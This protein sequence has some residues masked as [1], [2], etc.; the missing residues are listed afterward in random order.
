MM[1]R[2]WL[3]WFL[4]I[5]TSL[6]GLLLL[7]L[8]LLPFVSLKMLLDHLSRDGTL[9]MLNP[10]NAI[11][12]RFLIGAIIL[13]LWG[14]AYV[15]FARKWGNVGNFFVQLWKDTRS[16][17][18]PERISSPLSTR[19]FL[20][21]LSAVTIF[22]VVSRLAHIESPMIHDESF[23]VVNFSDSFF[24]A[25]SDYS[26]VNNHV[27]HTILVFLSI[28]IFGVAPWVARLPA[29]LAGILIIPGIYLLAK[30][31]YDPWTG[32]LASLLA[33]F[34]QTLIEY[35]TS[36]RGYTLEAL[37]TLGIL[38]LGTFVLRKKNLFAWGL[39]G[40]FSALGLFTVPVMLFPIG[41]L[42]SWL[43]FEN[44]SAD[45]ESYSSKWDFFRYWLFTGL[46]TSILTLLLYTP[47][48]I[49][50]GP[51]RLFANPII[52]PIPWNQLFEAS[53]AHLF[54]TWTQWIAGVPT[55]L[56]ALLGLGW[57]LALIFHRKISNNRI[58]LQLAAVF[59]IIT[60]L[61]IQRP[62]ALERVWLFLLPLMLIWASA[63]LMGFLRKIHLNFANR[64]TLA[65]V[66]TIVLILVGAWT[67]FQKIPKLP[68]I[69]AKRGDLE[70][71]VLFLKNNIR[72][73]DLIVVDAPDDSS[74]W[75]YSLEYGINNFH[76]D[77]RIPYTHA[78]ILVDPRT[79]TIEK[80]LAHRGPDIPALDLT[81]IR[82]IQSVGTRQIYECPIK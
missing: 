21:A 15:T 23:T 5:L 76:F 52:A 47:I 43:F 37:F 7:I 62:N 69:W 82:L 4:V 78:W 16:F 65:S 57:I 29:L 18:S 80:V 2:K 79:S 74:I 41:I 67:T 25:I 56:I 66:V 10:G 68:E 32:I 33:A 6:V 19:G 13:F 17:F 58:P 59:W 63:G 81:S 12:F 31:L 22:A 64:L 11:V 51:Q 73:T 75:F 49:F 61:L 14:L 71:V 38:I 20:I 9:S 60:L 72:D 34:S 42:F 35:S 27:F 36:A 55:L 45:T 53:R 40:L 50:T 46:L 70:N 8:P 3:P 77:K 28:K 1:R 44:L 39:I 54:Q 48:M 30:R 26:F 24:H